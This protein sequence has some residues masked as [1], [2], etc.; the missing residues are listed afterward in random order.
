[1]FSSIPALRTELHTRLTEALPDEWEIV[2]DLMAANVGLVPAVYFEFMKLDTQAAGQPLA[3]GTVCASVD[4]V[5]ADPR[6]ADGE[7]EKSIEEELVPLL[8]ALDAHTDLGWSTATKF[9]LD[10]GP[11]AWRVSLITLV[12]L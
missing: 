10:S 9:R 7:A 5:L 8:K 2:P 6:T 11:L 4:L 12:T 1:M 3:H